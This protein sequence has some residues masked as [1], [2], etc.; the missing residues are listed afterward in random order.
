VG[1]VALHEALANRLLA[2]IGDPGSGKTTFLRRIAF[3]ICCTRLAD[4]AERFS[5][6]LGLNPPLFP[7]LIRVSD[8]AE[9]IAIARRRNLGSL[10]ETAPTWL[11]HFLATAS[12]E[13]ALGLD[14]AFFRMELE[15]GAAIVML[16]GLDEAPPAPVRK[17]MI[18]LICNAAAAYANC[19]FV[20]TS[21]PAAYRG[22]TVL[23][24]FTHVQ[25]DPLEDEDVRQFLG[26]WCQALFRDNPALC[27]EHLRELLGAV[28]S[29]REIRRLARN[30]V[31]LTALAIVHW[32]AKR[33]PMQRADLY[34]SL[35]TWLARSREQ[36]VDRASPELCVHLLRRLASS[37]ATNRRNSR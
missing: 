25:I 36:R 5:S 13:A 23:S 30:P 24:G 16:D 9:P 28:E 2:I 37:C 15:T 27:N 18:D 7:M 29:R 17:A 22:D 8:L 20:L 34:E 21:R 33:L 4:D 10:T 1:R 3:L 6:V 32:I 26:R 14:E 35:I 12:T 11:S 31:M 19:H